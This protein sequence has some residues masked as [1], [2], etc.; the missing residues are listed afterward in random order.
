MEITQNT[1]QIIEKTAMQAWPAKIEKPFY[2]WQLRANSGVTKR[3]NS[4]FTLGKMPT[5]SGWLSKIE[6][7]YIS[8]AIEPCFYISALTPAYL[9]KLLHGNDYKKTGE[10]FIMLGQ[11]MTMI[12]GTEEAPLLTVH[13][14]NKVDDAWIRHFLMLEHFDRGLFPH[15]KTIFERILL[16]KAFITIFDSD[17]AIAVGTVAVQSDWGYV[18]NVVVHHEYRRRGIA[19]LL[20]QKLAEQATSMGA[21]RLFL[22]VLKANDA[23][24]SLYRQSGFSVLSESHYRIKHIEIK[25]CL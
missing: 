9:D 5:A 21:K 25:G 13:V 19:K 18:S 23:A 2:S 4:V 24:I 10:M 14:Q 20:M 8:K 12:K 15:Y 6:A 3:A 7:F 1:L 17:C 16:D 11:A 22:Q